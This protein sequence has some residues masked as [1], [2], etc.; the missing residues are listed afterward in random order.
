MCLKTHPNEKI[1]HE[2]NVEG[3]IDLLGGVLCPSCTSLH[4]K[5]E[6][7]VGFKDKKI[8]WMILQPGGLD[9]VDDQGGDRK[10]KSDSNL[11]GKKLK[12]KLKINAMVYFSSSREESKAGLTKT[13]PAT[14][15]PD[16]SSPAQVLASA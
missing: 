9:E 4:S 11:I 1:A 14:L 15:C 2:K 7:K 13:L 5:A 6:N 10:D 16:I 3:E 12:I 8:K